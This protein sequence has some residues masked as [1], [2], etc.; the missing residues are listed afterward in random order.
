MSVA[1]KINQLIADRWGPN[2]PGNAVIAKEIRDET[3]LSISTGYLWALR[4]GTRRNPTGP[5]LQALAK[6]FDRPPA[7]FLDEGI[8]PS[9]MDLAAV[10]RSQE[11]VRM[12]AM[13]SL[14]LSETSQNA[15]LAMV[16]QARRVEQLD[17]DGTA[18]RA[19]P[20]LPNPSRTDAPP[21]E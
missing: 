6:F 10:L 19:E 13:R 9:V 4:K 20:E 21:S 5:R 18:S 7:Y 3:G 12:I 17:N 11:A 1:D 8:T 2:P 16:E 14:E 15:I